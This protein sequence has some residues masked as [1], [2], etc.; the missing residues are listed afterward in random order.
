MASAEEKEHPTVTRIYVSGLP[1]SITNDQVRSHFA[2]TGTYTVT[3]AHVIPD[4]RISFIGFSSHEQ[5]KSAVQYFN[6]SFVRTAKISVTLARPVQVKRDDQGQAVPV[7]ERAARK[8]KRDVRDD[9]EHGRQVRD[10]Q[11]S[12]PVSATDSET[13]GDSKAIS[14]EKENHPQEQ[15]L[16]EN[17]GE[18]PAPE[19]PK[20]DLDWLRRKTNRT[21]DLLD[22]TETERNRPKPVTA[23]V[24]DKPAAIPDAEPELDQPEIDATQAQETVHTP[25]VSVPNARLF[26]RNLPFHTQQDDLRALF[27]QHGKISEVSIH[28]I[29]FL[30]HT[31]FDVFLIGT[32]YASAC[33][34]N[35][36]RVF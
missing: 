25:S 27:A 8:R 15:L 21:L 36:E 32:A 24:E 19:E 23:A 35:R 2:A 30:C 34:S 12:K 26:I 22:D 14:E 1:Q 3:D 6:K 16:E 20:S 28:F 29:P 17:S 13:H 11:D 4:R 7:S 9:G 33:D 31:L 5:A 18:D 10:Q